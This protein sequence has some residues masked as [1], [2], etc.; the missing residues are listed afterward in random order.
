MIKASI[1]VTNLQQLV[2]GYNIIKE[3]SKFNIIGIQNEL[4]CDNK[5]LSLTVNYA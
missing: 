5:I 3:D 1:K 2:S 4:G